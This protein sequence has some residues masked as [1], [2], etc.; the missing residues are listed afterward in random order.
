MAQRHY[1]QKG[2]PN[3]VA[4]EAPSSEQDAGSIVASVVGVDSHRCQ[5]AAS[6]PRPAVVL[7]TLL[8]ASVLLLAA[9]LRAAPVARLLRVD[10]RAALET[11][12][13]VLTTLIEI[14][15]SRSVANATGT[16]AVLTGDRRYDCLSA[17]L[18]RP[19]ALFDTVTF[20]DP[21][22]VVFTVKV[23]DQAYPAEFIG[24]SRWGESQNLPGVGTAWL[25][26]VDADATMGN[27][28][29]QAKAVASRFIETMGASDIAYLAFFNDRSAFRTVAWAPAAQKQALLAH[30]GA[31]S[32]TYR[33]V[34]R[35]R[36]LYT[37]VKSIA[38]DAFKSLG[39]A[40]SVVPVPLHQA[41]VL[42]STG[43]GGVDTA[44][45]GVGGLRLAEYLSRGRFPDDNSAVPK[46]PVPVISVLVPHRPM[47]EEVGRFASEFMTNLANPEVG[48][49]FTALRPA[50]PSQPADVVKA[51]RSRFA[52]MWVVRW[53][54]ACVAPTETQTFRLN[55]PDTKPVIVGDN[56]FTNVPVGIDPR[57]WPLDVN[58]TMSRDES[59]K[60]PVTPGGNLRIYGSYCWGG[61]RTRAEVYFLPQG[62]VPPQAIAGRSVEQAKE[63][64]QKLVSMGMKATTLESSD[65]SVL[66]RAPNDPRILHGSGSLAVVRLIVFDNFSRRASGVTADSIVELRGAEQPFPLLTVLVVAFA[67]TVVILLLV[68]VVR[69]LSYSRPGS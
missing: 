37:I 40:G 62:Q 63:V 8:L 25:I 58:M 59:A 24:K 5:F 65:T 11:G 34:G 22:Q 36:P 31:V 52:N 9:P 28:F 29:G 21:S 35:T 16:C 41:M 57:A 64:Q 23:G 45:N 14:T 17:R 27:A 39:D 30:I 12:R 44:T 56:S 15:Q 32:S 3:P 48:G 38:T 67:A 43:W 49:F 18:D 46:A 6:Q 61:N 1:P 13:P 66:V 55:F 54:V 20:P 51:V 60:S 10:P 2:I 26:L 42:I 69:G 68:L 4:V 7:T 19:G 47:L 33:S 50:K 53:Q